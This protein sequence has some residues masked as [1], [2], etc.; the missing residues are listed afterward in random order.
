MVEQKEETQGHV[1]A[2]SPAQHKEPK[3]VGASIVKHEHQVDFNRGINAINLF[4]EKQLL[5]AE[6]FL[7]KVMRS[8]KGGIKS[9]N[10]GLAV[11]IFIV[12][13]NIPNYFKFS[14]IITN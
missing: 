6:N 5:A 1:D 2:E 3:N 14:F 10:D 7:T 9:V 12:K 4:D 13:T 11:L 8:D